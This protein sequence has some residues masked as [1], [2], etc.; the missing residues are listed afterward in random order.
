MMRIPDL[1]KIN[2][3]VQYNELRTALDDLLAICEI[4]HQVEIY[5]DVM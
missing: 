5:N 4:A 1:S 3:L 2:T